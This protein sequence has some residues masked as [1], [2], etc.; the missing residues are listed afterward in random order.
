MII[1]LNVCH[2]RFDGFD[3]IRYVSSI[4]ELFDFN[5]QFILNN[6]YDGHMDPNSKKSF[7]YRTAHRGKVFK[8]PLG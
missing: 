8:S 2:S 5:F 6:F 3:V 1:N 7:R 4:D